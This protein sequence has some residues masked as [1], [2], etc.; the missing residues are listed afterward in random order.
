VEVT[1]SHEWNSHVLNG[2]SHK[3]KVDLLKGLRQIKMVVDD[4]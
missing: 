2:S 1:L 3:L 4:H